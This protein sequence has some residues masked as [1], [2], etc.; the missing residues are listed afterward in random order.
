MNIYAINGHKVRCET[1]NAGYGHDQ[2]TAEKYLEVGKEYTIERTSVDG[3]STDV[4]LEEFSDIR[5]NSV[6]FEDVV[7]Q[8]EEK[9]REHPDFNKY[10]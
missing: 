6:F 7:E 10:H 2:Q 5:F 4:W 8:S 1:F 3:W 9:N